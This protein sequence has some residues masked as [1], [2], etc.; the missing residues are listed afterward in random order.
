MSVPDPSAPVRAALA[1]AATIVSGLA[2]VKSILSVQV[3]GKT[4][5]IFL[6]L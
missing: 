5:A 4:T 1:A 3:P 6:L 2:R